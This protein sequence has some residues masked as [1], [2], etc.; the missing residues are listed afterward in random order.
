MCSREQIRQEENR[1]YAEVKYMQVISNVQGA[2]IC[3]LFYLFNSS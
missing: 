2:C 3:K 1:L